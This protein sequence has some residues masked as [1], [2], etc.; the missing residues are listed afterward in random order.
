MK[1]N[2]NVIRKRKPINFTMDDLNEDEEED[3]NWGGKRKNPKNPKRSKSKSP[4]SSPDVWQ[5]V[6]PERASRETVKN[7][8]TYSD[9]ESD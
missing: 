2:R 7:N 4:E 3:K 6:V 9:S 5:R 8:P 1:Q